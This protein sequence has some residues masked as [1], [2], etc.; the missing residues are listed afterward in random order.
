MNISPAAINPRIGILGG[1]FD[2][3][4]IGHLW[5]A[6]TAQQQ[7][8]LDRVIF[9]PVGTPPHKKENRIC[10]AEHRLAMVEL[11]IVDTPGFFASRTDIDR[12][13]P[14]STSTLMPLLQA[15]FPQAK[16]WML[17]G[18][19]GL[20]DFP[21]WGQPDQVIRYCRLGVLPRPGVTFEW[22]NLEEAVPGLKAQTDLLEGPNLA[23][24][25]TEL[26]RWVQ[27]GRSPRYLIPNAVRAYIADHRLYTA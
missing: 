27:D 25:A 20:R 7:L 2:P 16:L 12:P 14:H 4:H 11:A 10:D 26:R 23:I 8:K 5:L 13:P 9:C 1:T 19:D 3:P 22:S 18:S 21:T 6:S 17:I 15:Q 24:S